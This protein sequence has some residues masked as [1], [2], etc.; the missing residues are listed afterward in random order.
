MNKFSEKE[1]QMLKACN[2]SDILLQRVNLNECYLAAIENVF[3][4]EITGKAADSLRRCYKA[5]RDVEMSRG[6]SEFEKLIQL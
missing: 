6:T 1:I 5:I 2:V 3:M 4:E